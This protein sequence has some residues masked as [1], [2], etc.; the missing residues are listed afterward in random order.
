MFS[1]SETRSMSL[2]FG[3]FLAQLGGLALLGLAVWAALYTAAIR[4]T[5]IPPSIAAASTKY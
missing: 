2:G 1:A 5:A 3:R 4:N